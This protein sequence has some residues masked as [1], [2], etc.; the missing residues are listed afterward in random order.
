MW[1]RCSWVVSKLLS[2]MNDIAAIVHFEKLSQVAMVVTLSWCGPFQWA[3]A[4]E[5]LAVAAMAEACCGG[6]GRG[7]L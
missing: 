6:H 2:C 5:K 4:A 3:M 7:V 1:Q